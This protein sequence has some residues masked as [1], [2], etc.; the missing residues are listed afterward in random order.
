M[1]LSYPTRRGPARRT[2]AG[3]RLARR[4]RLA[5]GLLLLGGIA[6]SAGACGGGSERADSSAP[7][8]TDEATAEAVS[9]TS[10]PSPTGGVTLVTVDVERVPDCAAL[11]GA[12]TPL[13]DSLGDLTGEQASLLDQSVVNQIGEHLDGIE[14]KRK[15]LNCDPAA[16]KVATCAA[17]NAAQSTLA[18]GFLASQCGP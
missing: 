2:P 6:A 16:W 15:A 5:G 13:F 7:A 18:K 12:L 1:R 17:M 4:P 9:A 10:G 8:A 3:S 11:A 14:A